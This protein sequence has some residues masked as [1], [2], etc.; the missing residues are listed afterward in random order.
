MHN[1]FFEFF[2]FHFLINSSSILSSSLF[3]FYLFIKQQRL[4][5]R[6]QVARNLEAEI[7]LVKSINCEND[8]LSDI[9]DVFVQFLQSELVWEKQIEAA[10]DKFSLQ[11]INEGMEEF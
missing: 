7:Q 3:C 2:S 1:L 11:S 10:F 9:R 5:E 4:N 8:Y 6:G